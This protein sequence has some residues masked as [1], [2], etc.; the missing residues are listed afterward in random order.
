MEGKKNDQ[1]KPRWDLIHPLGMTE[2]I[3]VMTF[4]AQKY[5]DD[6]WRTVEGARRRYFASAMRHL[7]AWWSGE[8]YD[9]ESGLHH[10]AHAICSIAILMEP[11]LE[12]PNVVTIKPRP[13]ANVVSVQVNG[14]E[15]RGATRKM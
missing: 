10:L 13:G 6:N 4:G 8:Q 1:G 5:A 14:K 3:K 12:D 11:E 2:Y 15:V 9:Q 7:I